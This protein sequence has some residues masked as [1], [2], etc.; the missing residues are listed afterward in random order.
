MTKR[1]YF[2]DFYHIFSRYVLRS[3]GNLINFI[4][5]LIVDGAVNKVAN[6]FYKGSIISNK[7]FNGLFYNYYL[8]ITIGL[9]LSILVVLFTK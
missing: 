7:V 2:D 6:Y 8:W 1:Y 5:N 3:F 4:D 9:A